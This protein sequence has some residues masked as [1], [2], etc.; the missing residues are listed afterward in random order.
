M[1]KIISYIKARLRKFILEEKWLDDYINMGMKVGSNCSIHPGVIF[2]YSHCWMINIG[3]NVTIA[4]QAYLLAHDASTKKLINY[5]KIGSITI[6][7]N[8]FIGARALIMPGVT[9]G[10][11]SIV[12]AGAI[13]TKNVPPNTVAAGIPAKVVS[14]IEEY[15]EKNKKLLENCDIYDNNHTIRGNISIENKK[16]MYEKLISQV[17]FIQ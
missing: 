2:D 4:P 7:D 1:I 12:A 10:E 14:T 17:G 8:V 9:I 6:E 11:N 15:V 3:N 5:T 13:V 16:K